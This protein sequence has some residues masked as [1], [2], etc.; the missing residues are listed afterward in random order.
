MKLAIFSCKNYDHEFFDEANRSNPHELTY[1][2][3]HLN[4]QTAALAS[5]FRAICAFVNDNLSAHTLKNLKSVGVQ[6][7]ALRSA[8][9]NHIDLVAAKALG[10]KVVRVPRYSPF[11]VAEHTIGLILALNR[12]LFKA[13]NRVREGNFSL[14]GLL[15][16][17]LHGKTVGIAGTGEI[18]S[19]VAKIFLAF[20]CRVLAVDPLPSQFLSTQGVEYMPFDKLLPQV[21]ILTLHC[22]LSHETRHM[23]NSD[24][25]GLMKNSVMLIN[26][27]RGGLIDTKAV[28]KGLKTQKI[29]FLGLD[30]YEEE[31]ELFFDDR[32][33]NIIQDDLFSR[34]LTFPNV[35]ITGHQAFFTRE[36][37]QSIARTTL[38]N[39]SEFEKSAALSNEV[40][41]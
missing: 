37:L 15:G 6:L 10:L 11:S 4:E 19:Q 16:F 32:S 26:T 9:Y 1:F 39:V 17:D 14:E 41:I 36:A 7:I 22:P 34:L 38:A 18:G 31:G 25:I 23:I 35:M 5:G 33:L 28:I 20:G 29:G 2:D 24:T 13:Y 8:G 30:V 21:D 12:K 3:A 27:G 40:R